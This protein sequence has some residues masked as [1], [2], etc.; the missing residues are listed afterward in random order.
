MADRIRR[1]VEDALRVSPEGRQKL[2]RQGKMS[3]RERIAALVDE[4]S[5][6]EDGLLANS[7]GGDPPS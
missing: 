3:A 6:V 4:G 1:A 5:F 7:L 2:A